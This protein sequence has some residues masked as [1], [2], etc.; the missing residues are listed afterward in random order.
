MCCFTTAHVSPE[1]HFNGQGQSLILSMH[2][3]VSAAVFWKKMG[4]CEA[5]H[6][7]FSC[8]ADE[9]LATQKYS[10]PH[11]KWHLLCSGKKELAVVMAHALM[12]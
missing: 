1:L 3:H 6:Q 2:R 5:T 12:E 7:P 4:C 10:I 11:C 8:F 9:L